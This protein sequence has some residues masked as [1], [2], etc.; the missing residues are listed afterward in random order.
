MPSETRR[1]RKPDPNSASAKA[2]RWAEA[3]NA[4]YK[5]AGDKFGITAQAVQLAWSKQHPGQRRW[6]RCGK[7]GWFHKKIKAS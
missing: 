4:S 5:E 7:R 3:H 6:G 2:A 1:G